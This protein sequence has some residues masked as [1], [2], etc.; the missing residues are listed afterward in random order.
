MPSEE[1]EE[2]R[3][4][5][6]A[7]LSELSGLKDSWQ[8]DVVTEVLCFAEEDATSASASPAADQV[9]KKSL[10]SCQEFY[11][12]VVCFADLLMGRC[13]WLFFGGGGDAAVSLS[14]I[15]R[16]LSCVCGRA[17]FL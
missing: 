11:S 2:R 8:S 7:Y 5:L 3:E 1:M 16:L 10:R 12:L 14:W 4:G 9:Q 13:G 17:G 6:Q 15:M